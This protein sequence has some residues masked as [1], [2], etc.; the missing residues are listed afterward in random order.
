[1]AAF[2]NLKWK[3]QMIVLFLRRLSRACLL[4]W[5]PSEKE[6]APQAAMSNGE[7]TFP[8]PQSQRL[9]LRPELIATRAGR[10]VK[11]P[12]RT[13]F[14]TRGSFL[15]VVALQHVI[16]DTLTVLEL[17]FCFF[18]LFVSFISYIT[19]LKRVE[20]V[21]FF[22]LDPLYTIAKYITCSILHI[23]P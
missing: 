15:T 1:M 20:I 12:H 23:W 3:Q 16:C 10:V 4:L 5:R 18:F 14:A 8:E 22:P 11:P 17:F 13:M 21:G 2:T 7:G 9:D 6:V 19:S